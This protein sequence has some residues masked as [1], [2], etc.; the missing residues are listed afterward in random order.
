MEM[1]LRRW[2]SPRWI[3]SVPWRSRGC[4][5]HGH[6][7]MLSQAKLKQVA[8]L[9]VLSH[10]ERFNGCWGTINTRKQPMIAFNQGTG[11]C[12][13]DQSSHGKFDCRKNAILHNN[14]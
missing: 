9:V 14:K 1:C 12:M 3:A 11:L 13:T 8:A 6:W 4:L 2:I 5:S 7:P 10:P